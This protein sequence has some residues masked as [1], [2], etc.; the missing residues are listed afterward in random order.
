M[1]TLQKNGYTPEKFAYTFES[2]GWNSRFTIFANSLGE[3]CEKMGTLRYR[4]LWIDK[5]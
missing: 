3:A 2:T 1:I 4:L 5:L